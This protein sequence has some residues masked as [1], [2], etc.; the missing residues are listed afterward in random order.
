MDLKVQ[1]I[2]KYGANWE[3][4]LELMEIERTCIRKGGS[5]KDKSGKECGAG[6]FAHYRA[7]LGY[8]WPEDD[9]HRWSDLM[10]QEWLNNRLT[11]IMGSKDSSKTRTLSKITLSDYWCFPDTTLVMMTSTDTR[12]L[13]L[14]V[15]GD[16]K[17]LFQRAKDRFDWL[18]GNVVDA[19]YGLFTDD[20]GL[21]DGERKS[22]ARD[23]RKGIIGIP[24][25]SSTGEFNAM[26]LKNFAGIKQKRRRL[27]GD[28]LQF[29]PTE[30]LKAL[31]A[32][33]KGEFKASFLGNPIG[34]NG[35]A[36]DEVSEPIDG[37]E[38][39]G[40][41]TKTTVWRN[42]YGGVTINLVGIDSPNFDADRPKTY[43]YLPTQQDA[44]RI[45]SRPGGRDSIEWWS[46][47]MGVR[48]LGIISNRV[49]TDAEFRNFGAMNP[50]IWNTS[51]E[52]KIYA[53]DA[54]F[55]G[56]PCIGTFLE[57]GKDVTG[58]DVILFHEP[59]E[60]PVMVS[61]VEDPETQIANFTYKRCQT[62]GVSAENIFFE[63]GM[64]A[65]L[66]VAFARVIGAEVNAV[67]AGGNPTSRPV[68]N[69]LYVE[70]KQTGQRR[71]KRC[72]EHYRK[73][74]TE[75][76]FSVRELV[77]SGQARSFPRKA[78]LEFT[79]RVWEYV[80]GDRYELESKLEY[81]QR[82]SGHSPNF[83]DSLSIGLE[84]ARRRG[85]IIQSSKDSQETPP[86]PDWLE[87]E[88]RQER[89]VARKT[90]L[91]YS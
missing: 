21:E 61:S 40:E 12:G 77:I 19:W 23:M 49:L 74:I 41:I 73:F 38:S 82:N 60:I 14:R 18:E 79:K 13:E 87:D 22:A 52:L 4:N 2:Q 43:D 50:V 51:P 86:Q 59:D 29:I 1:K 81:K 64:R 36:L 27:V 6:L 90:E 80:D 58:K 63:A 20:I 5:W 25:L 85:F 65:T 44:D 91:N 78:A 24:C 72:D 11:V 88:L 56:D 32:L 3:S 89:K 62:I 69:S 48:K 26:S 68:N 83:A 67:N 35:K 46:L 30:Y 8:L 70:D 47:F 16:I 31:Y 53:V 45:S 17:E 9:H 15:W 7:L 33:D 28:E 71:L 54:G 75:V 55:G 66:A 84:G 37:W 57:C 10:L 39:L 76:W 42:K 34:G